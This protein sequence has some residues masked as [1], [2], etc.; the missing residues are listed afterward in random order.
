[1]AHMAMKHAASTSEN[2]GAVPDVTVMTHEGKSMKLYS[3]LIQDRVV[4][5]NFMSIA[6]ESQFPVSRRLSE[7][8]GLL[9]DRLGRDAFMISI[10]T[11]PDNDTVEALAAF[12]RQMGGHAGWTFARVPKQAAALVA[13]RFYR[14]GRDVAAGGRIDIIQYGNAK[15]GLWG[16]FPWDIQPRDAAER[17]T[18]V[19][20]QA[21]PQGEPRRAGPRRL[22]DAG[23]SWNNR[24]V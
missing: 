14:H 21:V 13:Q 6:H 18:W 10:T 23:Q 2:R 4:T 17:V 9:G 20:P 12:H 5:I 24:H 3:D 19:M 15:A 8:A 16:A 22:A 7:V 1:M 11:D